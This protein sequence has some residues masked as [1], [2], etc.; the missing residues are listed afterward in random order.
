M[1]EIYSQGVADG[2]PVILLDGLPLTPDMIVDT[3]N[4]YENHIKQLEDENEKLDDILHAINSWCKAYPKTIFIG[5][6]FDLANH[7]LNGI[8]KL[9]D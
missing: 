2:G 8:Q 3:L 7:V 1:S 5:K 4:R 9:I 6:E